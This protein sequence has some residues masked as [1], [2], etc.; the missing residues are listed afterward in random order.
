MENFEEPSKSVFTAKPVGS[1][2][3]VIKAGELDGGRF[4][5]LFFSK[6]FYKQDP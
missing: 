4:V 1:M 3:F 2:I 5:L 6:S